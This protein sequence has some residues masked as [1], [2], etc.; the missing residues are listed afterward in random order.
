MSPEYDKSIAFKQSE[1][2]FQGR[3]NLRVIRTTFTFK[4]NYR[5]I[6]SSK[7]FS[8]LNAEIKVPSSNFISPPIGK[9][10]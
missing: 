10:C 9:P 8:F 4:Q 2:I 7:F 6:N 5:K 3:H 1:L